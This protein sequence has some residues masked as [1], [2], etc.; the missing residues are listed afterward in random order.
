MR[1]CYNFIDDVETQF[2]RQGF[3][4][5]SFGNQTYKAVSSIIKD[6]M[7]HY[8]NFENDKI[9]K[10]KNQI[11]AT[12]DVMISNIDKVIERGEKLETLVER[13]EQLQDQAYGFR[14]KSR[15]LKSSMKKRIIIL[16]IICICILVIIALVAV[17]AGCNFPSFDRC[18]STTPNNNNTK[19]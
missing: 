15:K 16:S 17:F 18:R 11:D 9:Y 13:T 14:G 4:N 10:L 3:S 19:Q 2:K 5:N 8:N 12:K 1:I 7:A 6:R